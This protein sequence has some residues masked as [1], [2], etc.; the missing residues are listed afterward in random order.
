MPELTSTEK[1]WTEALRGVR[2]GS[3]NDR[4]IYVDHC[5]SL[6]VTTDRQRWWLAKIVVM[7]RKQV[8]SDYAVA[9][10]QA[11][12]DAHP[13]LDESPKKEVPAP[14]PVPPVEKPGP[15]LFSNL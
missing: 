3:F 15:D 13:Q 1:T 11:F 12:L 5:R 8:R 10:A 7:Y 4:A 2:Y 9:T 14:A 6:G